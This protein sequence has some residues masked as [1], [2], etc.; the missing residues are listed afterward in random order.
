M[1][2]EDRYKGIVE[3][4][5]DVVARRGYHQAS[6]RE[7]ARAASLSLA[8]LYHYVGG[9]DEL[10]F[11][12]LDRALDTLLGALDTA[13]ARARTPETKLLALIQTHLDFGFRHAADLKIIN[14]DW[15]LLEEPRRAEIAAKRGEY[16]QRGLALLR[17]LDPRGRSGDELLSATNLLL[18][19]LNGIATRPFLRSSDDARPLAGEV[20]ALFLY[21]FLEPV[22]AHHDA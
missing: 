14:R 7:I 17:E 16:L 4:A 2:I 15:E 18:G 12:V 19:M 22:E 10:L 21:G 8:G 1:A 3:A 13:L 20:G 9:K 5:R 11:L 6:I